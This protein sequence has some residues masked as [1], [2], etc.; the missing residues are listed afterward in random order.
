MKKPL[1]T[2]SCL[3]LLM[4]ADIALAAEEGWNQE[5]FPPFEE[6]DANKDGMVSMDEMR[7]HPGAVNAV[8]RGKPDTLEDSMKSFFS[9]AHRQDQNKPYDSPMTKEEWEGVTS[10]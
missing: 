10:K 9:P 5:S 4:G 1:I 2:M 8:T 6:V 3:T 7:T